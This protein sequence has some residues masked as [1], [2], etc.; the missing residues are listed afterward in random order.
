[1]FDTIAALMTQVATQ[2]ASIP[3]ATDKNLLDVTKALKN[4]IDVREGKVGN[5]LDANVTYRDLLESGAV[6]P[7]PGWNPRVNTPPFMSSTAMPDGYDPLTDMTTP[8]PPAGFTATGLF[9]LIQL[10]WD[11]PQPGYRNHSYTEIWRSATN[12]IG[13]AVKIGTSDS[14]FYADSLGAGVTRYYWVR[15]VSQANVTGPYQ[16]TDGRQASTA[17]DPALVIASLTGQIT[18]SELYG[19]LAT[20]ISLVDAPDHVT[21]SVNYRL[22]V[23]AAARAQAIADEATNRSNALAVEATARAYEIQ[24]EAGIRAQDIFNEATARTNAVSSLQTQINTISAASSGD[25]SQLIAAL[26]EEQTARVA[27]DAA[28]TT[29]RQTLASQLRGGYSGTD[30]SQLVTGILYNE[31][32]A[33][34]TAEGALSTS[35]NALTA[36][37]TNN[38]NTLNS[39]ITLEQVTRA[40]SEFAISSSLNSLSATVATKNRTYSQSTAPTTGLVI[41]DIWYDTL[42]NNQPSRW[43][44]TA[45]VSTSDPRTPANAA[46]ITAE[47]T[48]R[49]DADSALTNSIL[50]LTSTVNNNYSTLNSA[51]TTEASTRSSADTA[52]STSITSLTA[53]VGTKNKNYFQTAAPTAG[54]LD[55]DVWYDTDD[56]N[57]AYRYNGS[58]WVAT[59]DARIATSAAAITTEAT[60]R[61]NA[62]TAITNTLNTLS[63]TVA[64]NYTSLNAAITTEASTRASA[65]AALSTQINTVSALASTHNRSFFQT[66]A[67]ASAGLISGDIWFDSDDSNKPYRWSGTAWGAVDD[68]RIAVNAAAIVTEQNARASADSSLATSISALTSTVTNNNNLLSAS[69]QTEATT[70]A[71]VDTGLLAQY[72]V[73]TDVNGYVSGFGLAS[74]AN[75]AAATSSFAVRADTFYIANPAGPGVA[76]AMPFIVR[77]TATTINGVSVPV[78]VY[79]TDAFIQNGTITNAKIANLGVD[80]AKIANLDASKITTGFLDAGRVQAGSLDA[81]IANIDAAVITSGYIGVARIQDASISFAKIGNDIQSSD[82]SPGSYGWRINKTGNIELNNAVFRGTIDVKSASSGA[83]LQIT[84]SVIKVFDSSGVVRVKIGDLDA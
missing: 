60:A 75:N 81:K 33:R 70:R 58:A 54:M 13:D 21:G 59:D 27:A 50:N 29:S 20:R 49:A 4:I 28:E 52:L 43:T 2:V 19:S 5:P 41:G 69:L 36:T 57:K 39:A 26:Q 45:W 51:I 47:Q 62:D 10:Q 73:K 74:T 1:M 66:A 55:G 67:P 6:A 18:E 15:F 84:N 44:G 80:N 42:S 14:R 22:A 53:V 61:A 46:A 37:V 71:S 83:R 56:N 64:G 72:T 7:R 12:A 38:F 77:T 79:M 25:L 82:Y 3:S 16:A 63:S 78:G 68:G 9:A 11:A 76:P 31:R 32:Q 8:P 48:A 35:I 30:P 65:D 34:V 40:N 17:T 24:N 23:E